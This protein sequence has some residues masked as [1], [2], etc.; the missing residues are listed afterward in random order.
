VSKRSRR[1]KRTGMRAKLPVWIIP[2]LALTV[3]IVS[4]FFL[5]GAHQESNDAFCASCHSEPETEYDDRSIQPAVDLAS[6]HASRQVRCIDCHSG[7]GVLGR[8]EAEIGGA[9]N[10]LVYI[11]GKEP[12]FHQEKKTLADANC[13]KCHGDI[14]KK[15]SFQNHFHLFLPQWQKISRRAGACV[16]CHQGHATDGDASISFLNEKHT[17]T[18]CQSCHSAIGG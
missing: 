18:V 17:V 10:A 14:S 13:L 9:Q 12:S 4:A 1:S 2:T 11:L 7:Y 3:V 6:Q 5:Y 15:Q 16:D 8:M